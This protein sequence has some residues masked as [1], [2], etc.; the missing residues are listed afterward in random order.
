MDTTMALNWNKT[1]DKND[2]VFFLGDLSFNQDKDTLKALLRHLNGHKILIIGNHD[3][4]YS[5]ETWREI[6]FE[7]AYDYP[8]IY[9]DFFILSH[10][11]VYINTNM[12]YCNIHGHFHSNNNTLFNYVNVSVE[13]INYTPISFEEILRRIS[14]E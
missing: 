9:K 8:I 7:E 11:P 10:E 3:R 6:G 14:N 4:K 5:A 1:V 12:P 2:T 13:Q